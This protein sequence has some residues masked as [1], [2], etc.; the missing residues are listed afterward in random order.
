[1]ILTE[2]LKGMESRVAGVQALAAARALSSLSAPERAGY[3]PLWPQPG[4]VARRYAYV[5]NYHT[6][7]RGLLHL[8]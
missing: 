8:I 3:Y 6:A 4:S 1:M 2:E 7:K 5:K